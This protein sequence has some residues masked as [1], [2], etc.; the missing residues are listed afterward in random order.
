M[1][2]TGLLFFGYLLLVFL[3]YTG[4]PNV[5]PVMKVTRF[6]TILAWALFLS[7][8]VKVGPRAFSEYLQSKLLTAFVLFTM[9]AV[10]FAYVQSSAFEAFRTHLDYL[11]LF[12]VT[13]YLVDRPNRLKLLALTYAGVIGVW[14]CAISTN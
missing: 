9:L 1:G 4:L 13:L 2:G 12:I 5:V 6:T 3:E 11:G 14:S 7:I 10:P 8:L